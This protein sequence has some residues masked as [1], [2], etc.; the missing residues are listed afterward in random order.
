MACKT[1]NRARTLRSAMPLAEQRLWYP[2]RRKHLGYR[3]K[4]QHPVG[5]FFLDFACPKLK[6]AIEVDGDSH[7]EDEHAIGYDLRRTAL[8][9]S[10]GWTVYRATNREV[11]EEIDA[12]LSGIVALADELRSDPAL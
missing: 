7:F 1:T 11:R 6:L 2:L 5:P 10:E 8:L 4:R 3:F 9:Q 12:V